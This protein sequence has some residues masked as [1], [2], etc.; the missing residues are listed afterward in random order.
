M[1]YRDYFELFYIGE[2]DGYFK[3]KRT[4][5]EIPEYITTAIITDSEVEPKLP[6][7]FSYAKWM[8][9]GA[10]SPAR[11]WNNFAKFYNEDSFVKALSDELD[12]AKLESFCS[13]LNVP[14]NTGKK[15]L[16]VALARQFKAIIDGR[17]E[18]DDIIA[19]VIMEG[20]TFTK[21][22]DYISDSKAR[23]D[24]MKLINEEVV[25]LSQFFVCNTIGDRERVFDDKRPIKGAAILEYPNINM[26]T[27]RTLY[28]KRGID[29]TVTLLLGSGG[30]GKSLNL[31][32]MFL[33]AADEYATTGV[34]PIFIE[35]RDLTQS[36]E[37]VDYLT[38]LV[39]TSVGKLD[40]GAISELLE[41]GDCQLFFDGFDE[42]DPTDMP[43]FQRKFNTFVKKYKNVQI[44]ISSRKNESVSG[45][46]P[47]SRLYI[48]PFNNNQALTLVDKIL[49]YSNQ[50]DSK[51][52][53][54]DY[55]NKGFLK[56]NE[57]FAAHPL[58]LTFVA[59]NYPEYRRF[60]ENHLQFYKMTYDA[61]LT[62]HDNNKKPYDRV[63]VAVDNAS[64]FSKVFR[65][66][67]AITYR[68]A[69]FS[70]DT[71]SFEDYFGQL[72]AH[73]DFE[74]PKKMN[75]ENFKHDVYSTAC[76]MY[77]KANDIYYID[78]VFQKFLFA[79]YY[80]QADPDTTKELLGHLS[81]KN[82]YKF[83]RDLDAIDMLYHQVE[84]K[85]KKYI[86]KSYLDKI[87]KK[88]SEEA[89][90]REYLIQGFEKISYSVLNS[91]ITANYNVQLT[92]GISS[93]CEVYNIIFAYILK[94]MGENPDFSIL[95]QG[96][97]KTV[98]DFATSSFLG[99]QHKD[100]DTVYLQP[101]NYSEYI[102]PTFDKFYNTS[103]FMKVDDKYICFG[104]EYTIEA[105]DLSEEPDKYEEA[106]K[107]MMSFENDFYYI[108]KRL[109]EY[110]KMLR[111]ETFRDSREYSI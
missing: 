93:S 67:C 31:Q 17:G 101:V 22:A 12:D 44:I 80:A 46:Q 7:S 106:V 107:F 77:E 84:E 65:E 100:E 5:S 54:L 19:T 42:I 95:Y 43:V 23:Y 27:I 11:H 25:P 41:N 21:Y 45:I 72:E 68:D 51:E 59:L 94:L 74:N 36:K 96:S 88:D 82:F 16:C 109:Q 48:W 29:N 76:M 111:K 33:K 4:T 64:Q 108:F 103:E 81:K 39:E 73:N 83:G 34:L 20:I 56:K 102:K 91:D 85:T 63:F 26:H 105:Y 28:E 18:A 89:M 1:N 6:D 37:L 86:I 49:K 35:L 32:Y 57:I 110:H 9:D 70:F 3:T 104:H 47:T 58:L 24:V 2:Y 62:G 66:F 14:E 30:C 97:E 60:N 87:F 98:F 79:E 52:A 15:S 38:E 50:E 69:A 90:F 10:G 53:V 92:L 99:I 40:E 61:L 78:P 13:K 71:T 8:Q 55:I 75:L